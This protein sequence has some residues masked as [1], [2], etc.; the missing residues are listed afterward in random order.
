MRHARIQQAKPERSFAERIVAVIVAIA[1][2]GGMG[3]ATTSAAMADDAGQT[4]EQQ[5]GISMGLHDYNRSQPEGVK[6]DRPPGLGPDADRPQPD[7]RRHPRPGVQVRADGA[8]VMD[9]GGQECKEGCE[10]E[11]EEDG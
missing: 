6:T 4:L 11:R 5:A 3:Y 7:Q 9:T 2:L 10:G 8:A 1:M